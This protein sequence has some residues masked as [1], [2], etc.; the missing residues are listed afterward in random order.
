MKATNELKKEHDA[1]KV[2]INIM[3]KIVDRLSH[4]E[5]V[6]VGHL[7]RIAD[8][9]QVFVDKCHHA[10]EERMLFTAMREAGDPQ[11]QEEIKMLI[12][13]HQTGRNYIGSL[14][15]AI[16]KYKKGDEDARQMIIDNAN[17]YISL[18]TQHI[19]KENGNLFAIADQRLS[20]QIQ[21]KLYHEFERLEE[22]EIGH[23]KHEEYHNMIRQLKEFYLK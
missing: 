8:F 23:G 17:A 2:V 22:E 15:E 10:K 11:D 1:V 7:E 4:G 20:E 5:K 16:N 3:Q 19:E 14:L 9:L 6:D 13:D 18:I 21:F 12:S